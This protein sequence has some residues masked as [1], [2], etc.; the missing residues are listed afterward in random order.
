M[1][2]LGPF[3]IYKVHR[4][5]DYVVY[6]ALM[7]VR[8]RVKA[9]QMLWS[10]HWYLI[11]FDPISTWSQVC[12]NLIKSFLHIVS[13]FDSIFSAKMRCL[14]EKVRKNLCSL[15]AFKVWLSE[16]EARPS[17]IKARLDFK[18]SQKL[19]LDRGTSSWVWTLWNQLQTVRKQQ[20]KCNRF[21]RLSLSN[22]L[23]D[24]STGHSSKWMSEDM[25]S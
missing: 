2:F 1:G 13:L 17:E 4:T 22:Q 6:K 25:W 18:D 20:E 11:L 10:S 7:L 24:T 9:L 3:L 12:S 21:I 15:S 8:S 16:T 5:G 19:R 14:S 23:D